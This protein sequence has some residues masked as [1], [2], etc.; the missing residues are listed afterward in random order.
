[1]VAP[2]AM[3]R[4]VDLYTAAGQVKVLEA[5]VAREAK[6]LS[7]QF[8]LNYTGRA[9]IELTAEQQKQWQSHLA[10]SSLPAIDRVRTFRKAARERQWEVL[11]APLQYRPAA[12]YD[13][14]LDHEVPAW[15]RR[16]AIAALT[17]IAP[18]AVP[19][20]RRALQQDRENPYLQAALLLCAPRAEQRRWL[21]QNTDYSTAGNRSYE[22]EQIMQETSGYRT[23]PLRFPKLPAKL[24][25]PGQLPPV[26][27]VRT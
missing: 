24:K 20:L 2:L 13:T 1:M 14:A 23:T 11:L 21:E 18:E 3:R 12:T 16:E 19:V 26:F 8:R 25:L 15:E 10:Y 22:V 9:D 6:G 5:A 7:L 4:L 27:Q 17:L